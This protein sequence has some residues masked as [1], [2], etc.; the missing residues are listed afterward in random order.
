[1][2]MSHN[3]DSPTFLSLVENDVLVVSLFT[4]LYQ[5]VTSTYTEI[6]NKER[7]TFS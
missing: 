7:V 5:T 1:M 6:Y 2:A 4:I 3:V